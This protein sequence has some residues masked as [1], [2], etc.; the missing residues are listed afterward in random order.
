MVELGPGDTLGLGLSA[1]FSG[2][3]QYTGLDAVPYPAISS[4]SPS[5]TRSTRSRSPSK[6][7]YSC[8]V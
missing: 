2:V 1:M 5:L 6:I 8:D 4:P 7:P 3:A